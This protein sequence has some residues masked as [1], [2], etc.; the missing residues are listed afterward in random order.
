MKFAVIVTMVLVLLATTPPTSAEG[1][2]CAVYITGIGCPNCIVTDPVITSD[3]TAQNPDYLVIEYEIYHKNFDNY[4][5]ADGYFNNY[6]PQGVGHG[7]PFLI[8][9]ANN[10]YIGRYEVLGAES[11]IKSMTSNDC[12]MPDGSSVDF[13]NLDITTLTGKP[14]IWARGRVL[15]SEGGGAD[16][17]LLKGLLFEEDIAGLL[18]GLGYEEIEP[19]PVQLSGSQTNFEHAVQ[20]GGWIFQWNGEG[21]DGNGG[22]GSGDNGG[23]NNG[24]AQHAVSF[25]SVVAILIII[26]A[27]LFVYFKRFR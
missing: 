27:G 21:L 3:F 19:V 7:V 23:G 2:V 15:V 1:K 20:L 9:N 8:L 13:G 24:D 25:Y 14:N 18:G 11:V 22:N 12:P 10:V 17:E 6:I 5:T 4:P 26:I 16:N